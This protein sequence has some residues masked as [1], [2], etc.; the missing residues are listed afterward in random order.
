MTHS[1][2]TNN[3]FSTAKAIASSYCERWRNLSKLVKLETQLAAQSAIKI[4]IIIYIL[5]FFL[6]ATWISLLTI[7]FL[8]FI[9][10]QF[11][12]ISAAAFILL[13]NI[14]VVIALVLYILKLKQRI[15]F[16]ATRRQLENHKHELQETNL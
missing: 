10:L 16:Q 9:N 8:F 2:S 5:G 11:A 7:L 13:I 14:S 4:T 12:P 1:K 6:A 3:I 15:S